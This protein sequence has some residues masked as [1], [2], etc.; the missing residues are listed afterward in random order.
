MENKYP[1]ERGIPIPRKRGEKSKY[2][3]FEMEVGDSFVVPVNEGEVA[4]KV[5]NGIRNCYHNICRYNKDF[6][7]RKFT[8][9]IIGHTSVRCWR[10]K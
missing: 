7:D 6:K 2:P 10:V 9:R 8:I 1:I 4:P 5:A 3:F